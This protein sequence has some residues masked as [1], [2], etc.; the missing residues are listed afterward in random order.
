VSSVELEGIDP[1][2]LARVR[3]KSAHRTADEAL[4]GPEV[5]KRTRLQALLPV[6]LTR[7]G[8]SCGSRRSRSRRFA[9][10]STAS[11]G[12]RALLHAGE[13]GS[14]ANAALCSLMRSRKRDAMPWGELKALL[15]N[16]PA[17]QQIGTVRRAPH[18]MLADTAPPPRCPAAQTR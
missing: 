5:C 18:G 10:C 7:C 13:E 9:R 12:A 17:F 14:S 6:H 1:E 8:H 2:L 16:Q 15:L 4:A 11:T 3:A